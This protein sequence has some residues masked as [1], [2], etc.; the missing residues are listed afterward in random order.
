MT[1]FLL[2]YERKLFSKG[3][4]PYKLHIRTNV[5][6]KCNTWF[7][8]CK[9]FLNFFSGAWPFFSYF[10]IDKKSY[11]NYRTIHIR[12]NKKLKA[13]TFCDFS[14]QN[15]WISDDWLSC[16]YVPKAEAVMH[17]DYSRASSRAGSLLFYVLKHCMLR[18][19]FN[20]YAVKLDSIKKLQLWEQF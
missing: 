7:T 8:I 4:N 12:L 17:E 2:R 1:C 15:V 6:E 14:W 18:T 13:Q 9:C 3:D 20:Y 5:S 19:F 11:L 10:T 16:R